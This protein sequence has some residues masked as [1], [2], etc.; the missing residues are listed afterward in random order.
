MQFPWSDMPS[1]LIKALAK[2][3]PNDAV[4]AGVRY[5]S[6]LGIDLRGG[7]PEHPAYATL[8]R[9]L[10]ALLTLNAV[11]RW[12]NSNRSVISVSEQSCQLLHAWEPRFE[13]LPRVTDSPWRGG[14]ILRFHDEATSTHAMMYIEPLQGDDPGVR[15]VMWL[16]DAHKRWG[17]TITKEAEH[18]PPGELD[19]YTSLDHLLGIK[20]RLVI[21]EDGTRLDLNRYRHIAINALAAMHEDPSIIIGSRKAPRRNRGAKKAGPVRRVKRLTL[22]Y[23]G[24]RLVTRRWIILPTPEQTEKIE[25]KPH[26][27]PCLHTVEPH[28]W[29]VWVNTP[30]AHEKILD[31]RQ[32]TRVRNGK[33]E[34]YTQFRVKRLRGKDGPFKRGHELEPKEARIVT[35]MDDLNP[36][37]RVGP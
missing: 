7:L 22:S 14:V 17:T 1:N 37:P 13:G 36:G 23:D 5:C 9:T 27:P 6:N 26:K 4:E 12:L 32:K 24:A 10:P 2:A 35:G 19:S 28:Q 29:R 31:T 33:T 25:H 34:T 8:D 11:G 18:D 16:Q 30:K 15:Y 3:H 20:N 21:A